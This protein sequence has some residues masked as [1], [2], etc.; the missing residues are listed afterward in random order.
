MV[1]KI[2]NETDNL[3]L[4]VWNRLELYLMVKVEHFSKAKQ[5]D[6]LFIFTNLFFV[7]F[8]KNYFKEKYW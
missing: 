2:I 8:C 5:K 4:D 3:F 7:G 6:K 1:F